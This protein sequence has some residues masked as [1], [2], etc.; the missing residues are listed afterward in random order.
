MSDLP[1]PEPGAVMARFRE[2]ASEVANAWRGGGRDLSPADVVAAMQEVGNGLADAADGASA[3]DLSTLSDRAL[4]LLGEISEMADASGLPDIARELELLG[5]PLVLWQTRHGVRI[6]ILEPVVNALAAQANRVREPGDLERLYGEMREITAA[7]SPQV[8][9]APDSTASGHPWRLLLLNKAI[10]ATRSHQPRLIEEAY[11]DL[12]ARFPAG[13]TAAFLEEAMGQMD[14]I[15]YPA[16]VSEVV[17]RYYQQ[18][19]T[20]QRLH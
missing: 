11:D 15:G 17:N 12:V 5:L 7:T 13:A 20:A 2:L 19:A 6:R 3:A 10:V 9:D 16:T 1:P 14:A 18:C 4:L 8:T